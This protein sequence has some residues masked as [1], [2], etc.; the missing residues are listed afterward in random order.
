MSRVNRSK[1]RFEG[2]GSPTY[3]MVPDELFDELVADLSGA[4][5]K[6]LLYIIRR[7][8]GFK[9]D[10]DPISFNQFLTGITT[11]DGHRLDRGCGIKSRSHLSTALKNLEALGAVVSQKSWDERGE[12]Q[13]TVYMLRFKGQGVVPKSNHPGAHTEL[14]VVPKSNPQQT[15][16]QETG[17]Q[18]DVVVT[19]DAL[20]KF[21]ISEATAAKLAATYPEPYILAKLDLVQWL[22]ETRSP[23]V[24]K[25]PAGYLRRAIE[26]DYTAPPKYKS[27]VQR[28][29]EAETH[30]QAEHDEQERRR[31]AEADYARA[32]VLDQQ[33]LAE[34]Y[35]PQPIPGT[36]QTTQEAWERTLDEL[37]AQ[38]TRPNFEMWL[39][40]TTLISCDG[41]RAIIAAPSQYHV[42]HLSERLSALIQHTLST[43]LDA[44]VQCQYVPATELLQREP[45]TNGRT[46]TDA[47]P[48]TESH[49]PAVSP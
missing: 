44:P 24:G 49:T 6:V 2:F 33:K 23:L 47:R 36:T 14:P 46:P 43:V 38:V 26:E 45:S 13:T 32:K 41:Q 18:H 8:F 9:K 25:N 39:K 21:G 29:A 16:P 1:Q 30:D 7:T 19:R 12:N 4:E 10:R 34:H 48:P 35:P 22:V 3:T 20:A 28:Q 27:P 40:P 5:L 11:K 37:H 17:S 42:E 15:D 31:E